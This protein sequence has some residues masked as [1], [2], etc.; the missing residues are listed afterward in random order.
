T[1]PTA[2]CFSRSLPQINIDPYKP[3]RTDLGGM[4]M[5]TR[6]L[7]AGIAALMLCAAQAAAEY[8]AMPAID[9]PNPYPAGTKFGQLPDGRQWG[10]VIAVTP[11]RDGKS[12]W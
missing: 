8:T 2:A 7:A 9:L 6:V 1:S 11:D 12:I 4:A 5:K 3:G 10:G